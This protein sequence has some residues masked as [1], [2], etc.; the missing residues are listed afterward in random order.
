MALDVRFIYDILI[1]IEADILR[2][3][4]LRQTQGS[5]SKLKLGC[6]VHGFGVNVLTLQFSEAL[7]SS[8]SCS[9]Q[10]CRGRT[11]GSRVQVG[12]EELPS[13]EVLTKWR[14]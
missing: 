6:F 12:K 3:D 10:L 9:A 1:Y 4:I 7:C 2:H 14:V 5:L 11:F 8:H 13:S